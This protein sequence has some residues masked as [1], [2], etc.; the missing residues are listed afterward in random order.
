M[1]RYKITVD[2]EVAGYSTTAE[3]DPQGKWVKYKD[4]K[5]RIEENLL[6]NQ[7]I[8][9]MRKEID[10][11]AYFFKVYA[12]KGREYWDVYRIVATLEYLMKKHSKVK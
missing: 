3:E 11:K 12:P 1:K 6:S 10:E 2:Y 5:E 9:K 8:Q 7:D 4:V